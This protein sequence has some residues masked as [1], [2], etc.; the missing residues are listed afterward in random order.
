MPTTTQEDDEPIRDAD[1]LMGDAEALQA[2]FARLATR[3]CNANKLAHS[4]A[5]EL[6]PLLIETIK[7]LG[8]TDDAVE[9]LEDELDRSRLLPED[10]AAVMALCELA[11]KFAER[12]GQTERD[13]DVAREMGEMKELAEHVHRLAIK[14][15]A[16]DDDEDE[17][18]DPA[19]TDGG[20]LG[21]GAEA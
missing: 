5:H 4:I 1:E 13:P 19:A 6:V 14:A 15:E 12:Y 10:A 21:A 2:T 20:V 7:S 9:E 11:Q 18:E 17:D 3:D 8:A 16:D